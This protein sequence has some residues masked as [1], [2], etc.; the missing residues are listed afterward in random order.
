M[1][2][3]EIDEK[4]YQESAEYKSLLFDSRRAINQLFH[5]REQEPQFFYVENLLKRLEEY[6]K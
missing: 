3:F 2:I 1:N 4:G 6:L 5:G